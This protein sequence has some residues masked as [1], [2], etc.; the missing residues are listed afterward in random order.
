MNT[1]TTNVATYDFRHPRLNLAPGRTGEEPEE[2][3]ARSFAAAYQQ[4]HTAIHHGSPRTELC[5]AFEIPVNGLGIADL[6]AVSWEP[7]PQSGPLALEQLDPESLTVR[8]FEFKISNWRRGLMQANRY[9]YF[10]NVAILVLPTTKLAIVAPYI[11]TFRTLGVGLWGF[12]PHTMTVRT[13]YTPRP[14]LC[15]VDRYRSLA[16]ERTIRAAQSTAQPLP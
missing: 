13:V 4:K 9:T 6:V 7:A 10:A 3:F 1:P 8:A 16:I 14:D 5:L 12:A 15:L 2:A 11:Q